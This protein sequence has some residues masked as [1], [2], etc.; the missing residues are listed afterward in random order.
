MNLTVVV[1]AEDDPGLSL[2]AGGYVTKP[3]DALSLGQ[4][5]KDIIAA[6]IP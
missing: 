3:F 4:Q 5:V 6:K 2:G 1:L